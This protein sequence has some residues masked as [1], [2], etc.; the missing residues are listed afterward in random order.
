VHNVPL[1]FPEIVQS[2]NTVPAMQ[3][4]GFDPPVLGKTLVAFTA[5]DPHARTA[6]I[7]QGSANVQ[8]QVGDHLMFEAGYIGAWGRNLDRARL[9]NNAAPSPL[10]LRP[11]RPVQTISFVPGTVLP[12]S[13]PIASTTFPVGPINLLENSGRSSYHAEY[14]VA[15][16]RLANG[17]TFL[18]NYTYAHSYTDSPSFRSP[19]MEPEVPQDSFGLAGE[20]GP[21]GC[22]IRHRF[23]AS[24]IY[25]LPY[26]AS[27]GLASSALGK[28]GRVLFGGWQI[29][30]IAQAQSGFPFTI[31][32]FG[33]TANAGALL[34][35]HP[36]RANVVPGVSPYLPESERT[37]ER[38]F[39]TDAFTTP[40]A[41]TFGNAGRNSVYGPGLK[42]V[43]VA[44]QRTF[45]MTGTAAFEFRAEVFNLFNETNYGTPER[46]VNTPQFGSITMAATAA[47]QIQFVG[48]M[49]F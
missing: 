12:D 17:L 10:P 5:I 37:A 7:Q 4:F 39:N 14:I 36:V 44:L 20:W 18:A 29:A 32:V 41:F 28:M 40:P 47:R 6:L 48:R 19:A 34:N 46:F 16:Q 33:D 31:S 21:A 43:D 42:K 23:V 2:S 13:V 11:R 15:R 30:G 24:I 35:V 27:T 22:D 1:V 45:A 25:Q 26:A 38:W 9:V 3:G 8:H 49:R